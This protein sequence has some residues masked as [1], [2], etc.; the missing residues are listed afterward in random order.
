MITIN[1]NAWPGQT[2]WTF[3]LRRSLWEDRPTQKAPLVR[4]PELRLSTFRRQAL[5]KAS[6]M[7]IW[8]NN[9]AEEV[10][11][12]MRWNSQR[13]WQYESVT[14]SWWAI[15]LH[16]R[17][18]IMSVEAILKLDCIRTTLSPRGHTQCPSWPNWPG[19][20]VSE[21]SSRSPLSSMW[22]VSFWHGFCLR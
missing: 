15:S 13:R 18:K 22:S 10:Q 11:Y 7:E 1:N 20:Q 14:S 17:F 21:T 16:W 4:I 8:A 12:A 19:L 6:I 5:N 9:F 2:C 3:Q